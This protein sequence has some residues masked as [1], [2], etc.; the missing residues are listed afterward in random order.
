MSETLPK[1]TTPTDE[2]IRK[3]AM[4]VGKQVV[5]H[6]ETMYPKMFEVVPKS[7]K[8][9]IRNVTHNAIM[10]AVNAADKGQD[11]KLI[12]GNE[13][14]RRTM[15][16]LKKLNADFDAGKVSREDVMKEIIRITNAS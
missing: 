5:A 16:R 8:L 15:R 7:A 2:A 4:D 11:E 1:V 10:A 3:I 14:H 9:S 13:A 6:I 12:Q